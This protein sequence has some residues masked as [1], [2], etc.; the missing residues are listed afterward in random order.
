MRIREHGLSLRG[1]RVTLRPLTEDDW[2]LLLRWNNDPE[3]LYFSEG[4]DVGGYSLDQVQQIYRGVSQAAFCFVIEVGGVPIGEGW[5]QRMN[6]ERILE[7]YPG[8]DC[9]RIDLLI[10]E[11]AWQGQGLGTEAIRLLVELAFQQVGADRVFA[12]DIAEDNAASLRAFQNV[13]FRVDA[14]VEQPPGAKVPVRYDLALSRQEG[15][16]GLGAEGA[17]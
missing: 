2:D 7:R 11:R 5:L 12:C 4:D 13:G 3:I 15:A 8:Q 6:L 14:A 16:S 1:D 17:P 9:R 10:G